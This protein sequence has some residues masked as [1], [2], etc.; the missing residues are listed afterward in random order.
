MLADLDGA[1][2]VNRES[3]FLTNRRGR[4]AHSD[5]LICFFFFFQ[6]VPVTARFDDILTLVLTYV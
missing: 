3:P 1:Q 5:L 4:Y 6:G 2:L